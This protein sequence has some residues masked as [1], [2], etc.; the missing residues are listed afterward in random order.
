MA[1][2]MT[3][4]AYS[5]LEYNSQLSVAGQLNYAQTALQWGTDYF[6]KAHVSPNKLWGQVESLL[7]F[8]V[9]RHSTLEN[10][11]VALRDGV[12]MCARMSMYVCKDV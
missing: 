10:S 5:I 8:D 7:S 1:F 4:L 11:R 9:S 6:I 2:S 3:L 12:C